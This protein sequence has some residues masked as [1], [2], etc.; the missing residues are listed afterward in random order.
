[1]LA[2]VLKDCAKLVPGAVPVPDPG[3]VEAA[4]RIRL[5]V[6]SPVDK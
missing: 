4:V 5:P 1:V 2:A 6:C 3:L